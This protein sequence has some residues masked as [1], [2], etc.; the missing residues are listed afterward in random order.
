MLGLLPGFITYG[1]KL[2]FEKDITPGMRAFDAHCK[3]S[4]YLKHLLGEQWS[5]KKA[6]LRI[7][8]YTV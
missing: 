7:L 5:L 4:R 2:Y 1:V 8:L 3:F 6:Y